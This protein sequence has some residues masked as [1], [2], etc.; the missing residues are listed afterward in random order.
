VS[1]SNTQ[2]RRLFERIVG[3]IPKGAASLTFTE[4]KDDVL[5]AEVQPT[6]KNAATIRAR[7]DRYGVTL[8]L[9]RGTVIEVPSKGGRH[10]GLSCFEEVQEICSAVI[11]GKF[12]ELVTLVDS[13]VVGAKAKIGLDDHVARERWRELV[14]L[15]FR[16]KKRELHRYTPYCC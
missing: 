14:F 11:A 3:G 16:R 9:G 13:R 15:P 1:V 10:T 7:L 5:M 2:F 4:S 12:E 6:D 8:F